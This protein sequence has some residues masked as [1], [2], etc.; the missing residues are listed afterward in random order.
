MG[1]SGKKGEGRW[2]NGRPGDQEARK[3]KGRQKGWVTKWPDYIRMS[4]FRKGR[5]PGIPSILC[6]KK[7]LR[8]ARRTLW[9]GP[10]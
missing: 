6:N 4:S 1:G 5:G 8:D 7:G 3:V 10:L 9:P 2:E